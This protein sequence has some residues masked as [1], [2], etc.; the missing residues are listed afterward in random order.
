MRPRRALCRPS[1]E[2]G[3]APRPSD[4]FLVVYQTLHVRAL[5]REAERVFDVGRSK[6]LMR[7]VSELL[8]PADSVSRDRFAL[9]AALAAAAR[10]EARASEPMVVRRPDE[11][12]VRYSARIG[13]CHPGPPA[14]LVLEPLRRLR[15]FRRFGHKRE[16]VASARRCGQ[17]AAL[18]LFRSQ[19]ER[20]AQSLALSPGQRYRM[21]GA[22]SSLSRPSVRRCST[23]PSRA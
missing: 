8:V 23:K 22:P 13:P 20:S 9:V 17:R 7:R 14:L 5:S 15:S 4:S 18:L 16:G 2:A 6:A 3:L 1:T 21:S 19:R 11:Y 12:G 10:G